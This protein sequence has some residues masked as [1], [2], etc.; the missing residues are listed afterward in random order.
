M[1]KLENILKKIS[2]LKPFIDKCN[3]QGINYPSEKGDWKKFEK[4]NLTTA[5]NF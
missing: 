5:L 4:N 1:K 3:W 2:N